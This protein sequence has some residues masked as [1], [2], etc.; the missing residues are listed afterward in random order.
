[1]VIFTV[2]ITLIHQDNQHYYHITPWRIWVPS[3]STSTTKTTKT[4]TTITRWQVSN[5]Q[6]VSY[7]HT[8]LGYIAL[9]Q[10]AVHYIS[11]LRSEAVDYCIL[12]FVTSCH[13]H[14][15]WYRR[16]RNSITRSLHQLENA[17]DWRD[18]LL[19][20]LSTEKCRY[21]WTWLTVQLINRN[22]R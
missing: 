2:I 19:N 5:H 15:N 12:E 11:L 10:L 1:M 9:Y 16:S 22:R 3:S 21:L 4:T 7:R 6:S 13:L 17:K 18:G 20:I 8:P 14:M